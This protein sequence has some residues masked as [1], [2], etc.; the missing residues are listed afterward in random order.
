MFRRTL[1]ALAALAA[2]PAA[3]QP[4]QPQQ[5]PAQSQP[6]APAQPPAATPPVPAA[7]PAPAAPAAKPNPRVKVETTEGAF[8]VELYPDKAPITV[9][10]YLKYVDRGLFIGATCFRAS[11]PKDYAGADYGLV[12]CGQKDPAKKL[13]PIAHE[14]TIKTGLTHGKDGVI[15]MGRF[16]PGTAQ[17]DWSIMLGDMSYLDADKKDPKANPGFAAFGQV[18]EGL[19]VIRKIIV[20]PTDPNK[21]EGAMKGE[22]LVKP[23]RITKVSRVTG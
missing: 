19:E 4:A 7:P 8:V 12:Q 10:N 17:A 9:A 13:P 5:A 1:I 21:G 18:V 6:A 11:K 20:M 16:A 14:S 15:S 2:F 22:I 3:A 23:V